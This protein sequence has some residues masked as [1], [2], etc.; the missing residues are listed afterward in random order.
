M[1]RKSLIA[2]G[3]AWVF[4]GLAGCSGQ[5]PPTSDSGPSSSAPLS[6]AS[7]G[8]EFRIVAGSENQTLQPLLEKF[9]TQNGMHMRMDYRGSVDIM[10]LLEGGAKE[11]DAVWPANSLWITL[12]DTQHRIKDAHSIFWSPVVFGVKL[13]VARSL[14][15]TRSC[16]GSPG[17]SMAS[18][19]RRALRT[20]RKRFRSP[21][22]PRRSR[23]S[24]RCPPH[25]SW[26]A[27]CRRLAA[28]SDV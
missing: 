6:A 5:S 20:T 15:W 16:S 26:N 28:N 3:L 22:C 9:G 17:R 1:L 23:T 8:P 4:A 25:A 13:S 27:F 19:R 10:A 7:A 11:T 18:V 14:G 2:L 24:R 12:G 21:G